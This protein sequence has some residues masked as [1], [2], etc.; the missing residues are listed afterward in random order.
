MV[1]KD[2]GLTAEFEL[3]CH[4]RT[5]CGPCRTSTDREKEAFDQFRPVLRV[6]NLVVP[7]INW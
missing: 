3:C 7:A 5:P 6:R 1:G 4:M 2:R